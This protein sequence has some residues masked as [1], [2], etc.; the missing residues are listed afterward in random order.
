MYNVYATLAVMPLSLF[1]SLNTY[2]V[3]GSKLAVNIAGYLSNKEYAN[4]VCLLPCFLATQDK[5]AYI[6]HDHSNNIISPLMIL[7]VCVKMYIGL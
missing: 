4:S 3:T 6:P 2:L 7:F 1:T 5:I